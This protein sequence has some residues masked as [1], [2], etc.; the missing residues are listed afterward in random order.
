MAR[1][2]GLVSYRSSSQ[3]SIGKGGLTPLE[4]TV[5]L[6][7]LFIVAGAVAYAF[8]KPAGSATAS[9]APVPAPAPVQPVYQPGQ[10][11]Y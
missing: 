6:G 10:A 1:S 3:V 2:S 11:G 9:T 7:S 4:G 5:V 8:L